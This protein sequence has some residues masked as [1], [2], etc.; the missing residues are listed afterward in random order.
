MFLVFL[1]L[2][3][4]VMLVGGLWTALGLPNVN[5]ADLLR[6]TRKTELPPASATRMFLNSLGARTAPFALL[7]NTRKTELPAANLGLVFLWGLVARRAP[8]ALL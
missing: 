8:F 5:G 6:N 2:P 3:V 4:P 7:R 1:L